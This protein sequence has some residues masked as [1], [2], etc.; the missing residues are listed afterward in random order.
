MSA[1]GLTTPAQM[2]QW[3]QGQWIHYYQDHFLFA[4]PEAVIP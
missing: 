4:Q 1:A 2:P 3:S